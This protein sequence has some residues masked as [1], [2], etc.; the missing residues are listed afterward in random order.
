M[1]NAE[2][3]ETYGL[4]RKFPTQIASKLV[5]LPRP[6]IN[7]RYQICE[8]IRTF[9][10]ENVF[11]DHYDT[12]EIKTADK[13]KVATYK[14]VSCVKFE[15]TFVIKFDS[16]LKWIMKIGEY[17]AI[18]TAVNM[19]IEKMLGARSHYLRKAMVSVASPRSVSHFQCS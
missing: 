8:Q 7:M 17:P 14:C 9:V 16:E 3:L 13:I 10:M 12:S 1:P 4:Y 15:R 19:N 18:D 6:R 2:F 11:C 5:N